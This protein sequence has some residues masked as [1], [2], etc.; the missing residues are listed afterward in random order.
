MLPS[1]TY[2]PDYL[3]RILPKLPHEQEYSQEVDSEEPPIKLTGYAMDVWKGGHPVIED[4]QIDR[5][6]SLYK[7]GVTLYEAGLR[8]PALVPALKERDEALGYQKYAE[9]SDDREYHRIVGKLESGEA[10][11]LEN[12][13]PGFDP[14][15]TGPQ[16]ADIA[17]ERTEWIIDRLVPEEAI[18]LLSG[19][20]KDSGKTTLLTNAA[21][22]V[23]NGEDFMGQP[24]KQARSY[25]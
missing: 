16:L 15:L 21:I 4:G 23:I 19:K 11:P 8:R 6:D 7:I 3:D 14:F 22:K 25:I 13:E 12:L 20:M 24:V 18:T 10:I 5:S 9:R 1:A 2:E 17:P